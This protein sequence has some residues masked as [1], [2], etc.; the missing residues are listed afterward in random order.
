VPTLRTVRDEHFR[1][2]RE[3]VRQVAD[4]ERFVGALRARG[5]MN[6]GRQKSMR[7][8]PISG[9]ARSRR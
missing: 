5:G 7:V 1:E 3:L 4:L 6:H 9:I 2:E 8:K